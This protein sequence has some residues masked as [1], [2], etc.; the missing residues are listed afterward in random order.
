L[1]RSK[2]L[3]AGSRWKQPGYSIFRWLEKLIWRR[4]IKERFIGSSLERQCQEIWNA[5]TIR[6]KLRK[7]HTFTVH[8][9]CFTAHMQTSCTY[10]FNMIN[11]TNFL[12]GK[13][14]SHPSEFRIDDV[15]QSALFMGS[16]VGMFQEMVFRK[17]S[18]ITQG[19][20]FLFG[21]ADPRPMHWLC[22]HMF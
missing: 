12:L 9:Y 20:K 7:W 22:S 11:K 18:E 21:F 19:G 13:S 17:S 8:M 15:L 5:L 6:I 14:F 4:Y 1:V 3:L 10:V 2:H 16:K